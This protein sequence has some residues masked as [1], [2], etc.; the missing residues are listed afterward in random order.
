MSVNVPYALKGPLK[1]R[2]QLDVHARKW[3]TTRTAVILEAIQAGLDSWKREEVSV[4]RIEAALAIVEDR[5]AATLAVLNT[6]FEKVLT[7]EEVHEKFVQ[8]KEAITN[9]RTNRAGG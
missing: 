5:Q 2:D 6:V 7:R 1:L 4:E 3:G 9:G 8:T